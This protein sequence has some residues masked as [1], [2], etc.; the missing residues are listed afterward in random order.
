MKWYYTT[1]KWYF[2]ILSKACFI[3]NFA[4]IIITIIYILWLN[5]N[6][7]KPK[8][9]L[10]ISSPTL[11]GL[12][13]LCENA[14][15]AAHISGIEYSNF[16]KACKMEKDIRFSTYRKCAAGLGKEVLVIHLPLGTIESMI[17]PKTHVNGFYE[18]IEQDKLIKVLMAVMPSDG[19]KIFNFMEDFKKHLTSHDKEHLMKPFLSAIINLCQTL[20]KEDGTPRNTLSNK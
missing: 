16:L 19:M 6:K 17:E 1:R 11:E 15:K 3:R 4:A 12:A 14:K 2:N 5:K 18:T 20:L 13:L 9:H 10:Y 8:E 7:L